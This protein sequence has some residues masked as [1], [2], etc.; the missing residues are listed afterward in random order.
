MKIF[1][2]TVFLIFIICNLSFAKDYTDCVNENINNDDLTMAELKE[3]CGKKETDKKVEVNSLYLDRISKKN[4]Y[5]LYPHKPN[6]ILPYTY[7]DNVNKSPFKTKGDEVDNEEIKFQVSIKALILDDV[8]GEDIDLFF[9]YTNQSYW[10]AYNSDISSPFRETNHEPELWLS[11]QD[12]LTIPGFDRN[13]IRLGA[14]H[15]SNG[16]TEYLSR[17]WNR[18]YA[19][20]I[21]ET[22]DIFFSLKPWY[23][24]PESDSDDDN[25]NTEKYFGYGEFRAFTEYN[26][27]SFSAMLRNN[28]RSDNKGAVQLDFTFPI[29]Y[30]ERIKGYVQYFNGYGES[31]LD[32]DAPVNRIGAGILISDWN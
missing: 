14:V 5:L 19:E 7:N 1:I 8:I 24:I 4:P 22:H 21:V 26:G 3:K 18:L 29:P 9:A 17:S 20:I 13:T 31:L 23:R 16:R 12:K 11:F 2:K 15:Q 30:I 28:L 6:Y 25:P 10:Q 27:M 32:Y